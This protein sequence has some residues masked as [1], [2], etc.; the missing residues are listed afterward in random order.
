MVAP[1]PSCE[2]LHVQLAGFDLVFLAAALINLTSAVMLAGTAPGTPVRGVLLMH[3]TG[4]ALIGGSLLTLALRAQLGL[5]GKDWLLTNLFTVVGAFALLAAV[6][7]FFERRV[8]W[9]ALGIFIAMALVAFLVFDGAEHNPTRMVVL[10]LA[11][12]IS[13]VW[14]A[15]IVIRHHRVSERGPALVMAFFL[16]TNATV[17]T[18]GVALNSSNQYPNAT[19][20]TSF[21]GALVGIGV[22]VTLLLLVARRSQAHLREL[23]DRDML[24][25]ALTRR[26]LF[27]RAPLWVENQQQGASL[28]MIDFDRFKQINDRFGHLAGDTVLAEGIAAMRTALPLDALLGRFGG[29]EFVL[30]LP[31]GDR[32]AAIEAMHRA[33]NQAASAALGA[34]ATVSMGVAQWQPNES[35]DAALMRADRALYQAKQAGRNAVVHAT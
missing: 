22:T 24:T 28:V 15:V 8:P 17:M 31:A 21:F 14:R 25:G 7:C 34:S 9:I 13:M 30:L 27:E 23:L 35:I 20:A 4:V 33:V 29:E 10:F 18:V 12:L 11:M 3:A 5:Q 1:S 32:N 26:A 16:L 19:A 2:H 6:S